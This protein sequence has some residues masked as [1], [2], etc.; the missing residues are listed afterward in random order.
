M[1]EEDVSKTAFV[2]PYGAHEFLGMAFG[3]KTSGATLVPELR[4]VL[5]GMSAVESYIDDLVVFSSNW[6]TYLKILKEFLRRLSEANRTARSVFSGRPQL[7]FRDIMSD[8]IGLR[9]TTITG[10]NF[11]CEAPIHKERSMIV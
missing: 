9:R 4:E 6:K 3:I 5:L 7:N 1:A 2:T 11:K 10:Q 8:M